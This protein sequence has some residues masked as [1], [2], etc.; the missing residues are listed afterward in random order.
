[1][2]IANENYVH[3][4]FGPHIDRTFL[5]MDLSCLMEEQEPLTESTSINSNEITHSKLPYKCEVK[6]CHYTYNNGEPKKSATPTPQLILHKDGKNWRVRAEMMLFKDDKLYLVKQNKVNQYGVTYKLPGGGIDSVKE[7][8][9]DTAARECKEEARIIPT[10]VVYT[11]VEV[12]HEYG[13]DNI[14]KWHKAILHPEGIYYHG[15]MTFICT[16][17][18]KKEFKSY[19]KKID[20]Q[21]EMTKGHFYTYEQVEGILSKEHKSLF[22]KYLKDYRR[23]QFMKEELIPEIDRS[24]LDMDISCLM[25]ETINEDTRVRSYNTKSRGYWKYMNKNIYTLEDFIR[26]CRDVLDTMNVFCKN[27]VG[28]ASVVPD[29]KTNKV[30]VLHPSF[31]WPDELIR[32]NNANCIEYSY[33]MHQYFKHNA[34]EHRVVNIIILTY[35]MFGTYQESH[36]YPVFQ[37]ANKWYFWNYRNDAN[38]CNFIEPIEGSLEK[39]KTHI[40]MYLSLLHKELVKKGLECDDRFITGQIAHSS[41]F[42]KPEMNEFDKCF[43]ENLEM[44][45]NWFINTKTSVMDRLRKMFGINKSLV[46]NGTKMVKIDN[47]SGDLYNKIDKATY[48]KVTRGFFGH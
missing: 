23:I 10:N 30:R 28:F 13:E 34:I 44:H 48:E 17:N 2:P 1:M 6:Q 38:K 39:V 33:M 26:V 22:K 46:A 35:T 42:T 18:Y 5:E 45:Q 7:G 43:E 24:F 20:Q 41:E 47:L 8:I 25:E 32:L 16:G 14:P 4:I 3:E 29:E 21:D 27:K 31:I 12:Q 15:S 11:G 40:E 37:I 9:E 19:V 36:T